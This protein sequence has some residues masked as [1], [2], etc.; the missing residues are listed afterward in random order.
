MK[1]IVVVQGRF[2]AFDLARELT[3]RGALAR[4]FTSYPKYKAAEFGVRRHFVSTVISNEIMAR[5]WNKMPGRWRGGH[6]AQYY[7][8]ERFDRIVA[9]RLFWADILVGWSGC[10]LHTMHQAKR[11]GMI[12]ILERGSAHM[13][14][15][16]K[17]LHDEYDMLGLSYRETHPG[18]VEK[19][20][21]E[22]ELADYIAIPSQFV[23][24]S[25][26]KYGISEKKLICNPYGVDLDHFFPATKHDNVFRIIHCGAISIRK[27][28]QYLVRA[29]VELNLKN[30][31]LWLVGS[32]TPEMAPW[33]KKYSRNNI[34]LHGPKPQNELSQY[35][36]QCDVFCVAS[37]EEGLAMVI[38][39]AMACG[40]PVICT[41]NSGGCDVVRN[42]REG[43]I[44]PIRDVNAIKENILWCYENRE[45]CQAMGRAA[46]HRAQ[47][48]FTWADYG[49]RALE[50][51]K[52][53]SRNAQP[54]DGFINPK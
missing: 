12:T 16:Q 47:Q 37:I 54:A 45:Q 15:Q 38:L 21:L 43:F 30:C 44:V 40:L 52:T 10:S 26:Q 39:Q 13:L 49:C 1:V 31:E 24:Q 9:G 2:H 8:A 42:H 48:G 14:E 23:K 22:Y 35:Y 6:N 46:Q 36:S 41:T 18:I 5:L 29:F 25:F 17:L 50:N 32:I 20:L 27:G 51:Y 3:Q 7:L 19:E 11:M 33:I 28:V 4:L 53:I 34:V